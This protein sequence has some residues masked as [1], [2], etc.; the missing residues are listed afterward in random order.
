MHRRL[1]LC[2]CLLSLIHFSLHAAGRRYN[3]N[4]DNAT[5]LR[6]MRDTIDML[7]HEVENHET[8]LR[9]FEEKVNTQEAT[10]ASLRQQVQDAMQANKDLLKSSLTTVEAKNADLESANKSL[11][12]DMKQLKNHSND[13]VEALGQYKL[14]IGELEKTISQH[15]HNMDNMQSA[16]KSMMDALQVKEAPLKMTSQ[17]DGGAN[18]YRVKAGDSLEKIAK[19]NNTTVKTLKEI[20]SLNSDK[21][22]VGQTIQL[23]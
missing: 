4:E 10:I 12:A 14:K 13:W 23:P 5:A 3:S 1:L 8:E 18:S 11:V 2:L 9:M 22:V 7:R 20:N 21:I 6:E 16:M 19:N 17:S 15:G